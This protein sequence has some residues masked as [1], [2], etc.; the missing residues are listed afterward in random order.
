MTY[1]PGIAKCQQFGF[2]C[3]ED[4]GLRRAHAIGLPVLMRLS[5]LYS[6]YI[7][8]TS[9]FKCAL[10]IFLFALNEISCRFNVMKC[11]QA[12]KHFV[13]PLVIGI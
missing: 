5:S 1:K 10:R 9:F 7:D 13:L 4:V 3:S 6:P 2:S 11:F 8:L 12:I